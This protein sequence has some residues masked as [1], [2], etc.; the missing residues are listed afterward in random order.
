MRD[1]FLSARWRRRPLRTISTEDV[2]AFKDELLERSHRAQK[3]LVILRGVTAH[4][5]RK[6][7]IATNPDGKAE[8]VTVKPSDDSTR[9]KLDP[10]AGVTSS[11]SVSPV[12]DPWAAGRRI[13]GNDERPALAGLS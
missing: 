10:V 12:I 9:A 3:I 8:T 4:A 5:R 7:W 11:G 6:G 2:D 1:P 13:A